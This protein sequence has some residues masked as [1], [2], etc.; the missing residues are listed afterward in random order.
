MKNPLAILGASTRAAA[1]S[2]IRSGF[3]PIA[4]DLFADAD[5]QAIATTTRIAPYPAGLVDWLRAVEPPAWMYTGALENHAD[6]IDQMAWIATLWGNPGDVLQ[7]VRSPWELRDVLNAA[8]LAFPETRSSC[9]GLPH[10]GSWLSKTYESASGAGVRSYQPPFAH[11]VP[12]T[13]AGAAPVAPTIV[14]QKRIAG[15]PA[16]AIYVAAQ[17]SAILLG[18]TEQRRYR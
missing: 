7:R 2:A 8:G 11:P 5:L 13:G 4:A 10:D 9:Q 15:V 12:P 14:Y 1:A 17:G 3:A 18:I 6:L 16:A